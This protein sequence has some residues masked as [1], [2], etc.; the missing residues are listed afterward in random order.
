[1]ESLDGRIV[2]AVFGNPWPVSNLTLSFAPDGTGVNGSANQLSQTFSAIP[3]D[4]WQSEVLRAFQTWALNAN[5]NIGLVPDGG[6][7]F[8]TPGSPQGDTRFG[9]VRVAAVPLAPMR[10]P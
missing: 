6:Q 5:V 7:P 2:P 4:L 3:A 9:D 10:S 1:L 8:G